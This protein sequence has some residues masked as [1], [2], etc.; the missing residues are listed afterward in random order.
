V[1]DPIDRAAIE[2]TYRTICTR[3]RRTPVLDLFGVTLKLEQLQH[4][5]SF[6]ARGAIANLLLRDVPAA[7]VVAASGAITGR[8]SPGRPSSRTFRRRSSSRRSPHRP[9]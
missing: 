2:Q 3:V 7:G 4:A 8:P 5:G 6:K 1:S 9:S